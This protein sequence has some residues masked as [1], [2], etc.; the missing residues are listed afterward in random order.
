MFRKYFAK[1]NEKRKTMATFHYEVSRHRKADGTYLVSVRMTHGRKLVR[2]PTSIFVTR[3]QLSRDGH[4]V[5]DAAVL[6]AIERLLARLRAAVGQ[7]DCPEAYDAPT[8][9]EIVQERLAGAKGFRLDFIA[10]AETQTEG[11]EK[12]TADGYRYSL[13]AFRKFLGRDSVDVNDIDKRMVAEFL[14]WIERRNGKGCRAGSF[15]LSH[16]AR[17]HALARDTYN[18]DDVVLVRIPRQPFKGMIPPQP[19]TSHRDLTPGQVKAIADCK[20]ETMRG[21][22]AR[23]VFVLSFCLCGMNTADIYRIRKTDIADGVLTYRRAKTDSRRADKA[24]MRVR[25]EPEAEA[26][27]A[28]YSGT[29]SPLG[30]DERYKDFKGFNWNVNKGLKEVGRLVGVSGLSS[31]FA[32]H[33]WATIA[34]NDC[35]VDRDTVNEALGHVSRDKVTDIYIARDW[36]R[37][38]DANRRVLDMVF[39]NSV[40]LQPHI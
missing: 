25:I 4:K 32:R 16:L 36:R 40:S 22:L 12:G 24:E 8:L 10:F 37:V 35:G 30:F 18:D 34:R 3:D 17:L 33:S 14:A 1:Y 7:I 20:P 31:Y 28:R 9:W 2:R 26:V 15:Y 29:R 39:K 11:M 6:D 5:R 23:D 38:W 27:F 19:A 13:N 21:Q